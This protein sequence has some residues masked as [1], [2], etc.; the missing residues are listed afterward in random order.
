MARELSSAI[1]SQINNKDITRK[2]VFRVN[3]R[4]LTSSLITWNVSNDK[5]FGSATASFLLTNQDGKH[6]EGG[7]DPIQ[8]GDVVEFVERYKGDQT[9]FKRF[10]GKVEQ[11][12]ISKSRNERTISLSCLDYIANMRKTDI[13][14]EVEGT[15]V[16]ITEETLVPQFLPAP[17]N[18]LAQIFNFA[19]NAIASD[20]PPV[21]VIRPKS[22]IE[23]VAETPQF[24]G[25][26][27]KYAQGQLILGTPLN[28]L[29]N[30]DV[31]CTSY[32]FYTEGVYIEDILE[33]IITAP[34]G[35]GR[36]IFDETSAQDVIDNHLTE[37]LINQLG[38]AEDTLVPNYTAT[39]III[40]TQLSS[41][42]SAG[43][44]SINVA[45]TSGFPTS[46]EGSLNGDTFTWT[47]KTAT[48]L[49]GIPA[50]GANALSAHPN[51][52]YVQYEGNYAAGRVWYLSYSNITTTLLPGTFSGLA[53][54][55]VID[56][57]DYRF[58]RIILTA[59]I[60]TSTLVKYNGNYSF[61][62]LQA[63]GTQI[64]KIK[65]KPRQ[66]SDRFEAIS[67]VRDFLAPNYIIRTQGD[68]KIWSSYLSQKFTPDYTLTLHKQVNFLEDEDLFTRVVFYGK[69]INPTN[70]MF[71]QGVGFLSTGVEYK[72]VATQT[73]LQY[74]AEE[75][76]HYVYKTTITD[77]GR[78]DLTVLKPTV[79]I[80]NLPVNNTPQTIALSPVVVSVTQ[81]TETETEE[82]T[83]DAPEVTVHQYF[84]Y[85]V[86]FS[87]TSIDP[88]QPIS[89]Y[90]DVG[91]LLLTISPNN[92]NMDYGSGVYHVPG[93]S[94]N[95]VIEQLSTA[96]YVV[97][98]SADG[99]LIDYDTVRFRIA[100]SLLPFREQ[101]LVT[102]TFQYWTAITPIS[103]IAAVID[104]RFDSQVQ[105]SFFA[106]PP[107]GLQYAI[108]DLGQIT[109]I[110]AIDIVAGFFRPDA[111]RKF[112]VDFTFSLKYSLDNVSYFFISSETQNIELSGGK[113]VSFE[114]EKLG[115][116]F[117]ARYLMV[118]LEDVKKLEYQSPGAATVGV[119]PVAF[120]EV[121]AYDD[122]VLKAE[123]K[124]IPTTQLNENITLGA[125]SGVYPD[126]IVVVSTRNFDVPGS[127]ERLTAYIGEDS[128]T[129]SSLTSTTFEGVEG[130]SSSHSLGDRVSQTLE[131]DTTFY[132]DEDLLTRLGD[133][134]FKKMEI[135]EDILYTQTQLNALA[136]A[137][138]REYYK[139]HSKLT[140]TVM[141]SPYLMI[142]QTIRITD[143]YY[144]ITNVDYFI[145]S[146]TES[147][148]VYDL[149]LARYPE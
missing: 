31:V 81:R 90:N 33:D 38:V 39:D 27:I 15:K 96:S 115:T 68:N 142:G 13:D 149:V 83:S 140:V 91:S 138:L 6:F 30:Y 28:A 132:D 46:G 12:S 139:N 63:T 8:V 118:I 7:T 94:Q 126:R 74:E 104:G 105:S 106:E 18:S 99:I 125:S 134:L 1:Q 52:S 73:T 71:R 77:A 92:G 100:K 116:D 86:R 147:N 102:A 110:Q 146:I 11:R 3:D 45:S 113:S 9:E 89:L 133:R 111:I 60:S 2:H 103:D 65:F 79:Y 130:L 47:G 112:D 121:S 123:A 93:D 54:G 122:I 148:G 25:F 101:Q 57:I 26:N 78:I 55:G 43:A 119:W 53:S 41:A 67:K 29:N 143:S 20:P 144:H 36:Y 137:Y 37:T 114:E 44:T 131:G 21:I 35:Y 145:E 51:G 135:N 80:N 128:F 34:D 70:V 97:F 42:V 40:K 50:S 82:H 107:N 84:Y 14:L 16:E 10:Y 24:D 32:H 85:K 141:Y 58:G 98:Y 109:Q 49:T 64:N 88:T 48:S 76:N 17:N 59:A 108:L 136:K 124:L 62:T 19:N 4:D 69:N 127:G 120:S 22:G 56:Y 75:A 95:S 61:K 117:S 5:S 87:H 23:L 72:A 129:Y 66:V